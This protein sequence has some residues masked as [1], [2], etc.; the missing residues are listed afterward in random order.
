MS[1][2]TTMRTR[3]TTDKQRRNKKKE[4][5]A[6]TSEI[7]K[8]CVFALLTC[9]SALTPLDVH[10]RSYLCAYLCYVPAGTSVHA[11]RV[12]YRVSQSKCHPS[13]V[14]SDPALLEDPLTTNR[15]AAW[16]WS[17]PATRPLFLFPFLSPSHFL[18]LFQSVAFFFSS[19]P[20]F[21]AS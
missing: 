21:S 10:L 16:K 3:M 2:R 7:I 5:V 9:R 12:I 18:P 19:F 15:P 17:Q 8:M 4:K 6:E 14:L 1:T 20:S 11:E 13:R